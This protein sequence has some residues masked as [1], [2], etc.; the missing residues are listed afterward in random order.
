MWELC[1]HVRLSEGCLTVGFPADIAHQDAF[2]TQNHP[3]DEK[4]FGRKFRPFTPLV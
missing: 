2:A 4:I 3:A 1:V